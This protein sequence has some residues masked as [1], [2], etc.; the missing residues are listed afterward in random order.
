MFTLSVR[1][2]KL[3]LAALFVLLVVLQTLSFPGGFR[4]DAEQHPDEA[5]L[6]WPLTI[7]VG[8][9]LLAAEVV[10]VGIW[11]ILTLTERRRLQSADALR[12]LTSITWACA[13][14]ATLM[15]LLFVVI[16]VIADD[17]GAPMVLLF[18]SLC[19]MTLTLFSF[20]MRSALAQGLDSAN[21]ATGER[22]D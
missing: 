20:V 22:H 8:S 11:Q 16:A 15:T 10:V 3:V 17:P 4:Y 12:W 1:A 19:V 5:Y 9:V 6:Q 21:A 14:A 18:V 2:L 7:A 13:Y